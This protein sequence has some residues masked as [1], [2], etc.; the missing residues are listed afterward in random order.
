MWSSPTLDTV[1]QIFTKNIEILKK[2][3]SEISFLS[4]HDKSYLIDQRYSSLKASM[5]L[6]RS[7]PPSRNNITTSLARSRA[8][9]HLEQLSQGHVRK[10]KSQDVRQLRNPCAS[11]TLCSGAGPKPIMEKTSRSHKLPR[12]HNNSTRSQAH[13]G[14][15]LCDVLREGTHRFPCTVYLKKHAQIERPTFCSGPC[16]QQTERENVPCRKP[17]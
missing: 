14:I 9:V 17:K 7:T 8:R 16:E 1:T 11:H 13:D 3:L 2:H 6:E 5:E 10:T 4:C 15:V 12:I